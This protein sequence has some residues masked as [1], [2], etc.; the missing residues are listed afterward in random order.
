[1]FVFS[2]DINSHARL[3]ISDECYPT[4]SMDLH[5]EVQISLYIFGSPEDDY[6]QNSNGNYDQKL[7]PAHIFQALFKIL[8]SL[9]K[10]FL[11]LLEVPL[12]CLQA[13][14][15]IGEVVYGFVEYP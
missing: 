7:E 9:H 13:H 3:L 15:F 5:L 12:E 4:T 10:L 6:P 2:V 1:L 14:E 8:V 11:C